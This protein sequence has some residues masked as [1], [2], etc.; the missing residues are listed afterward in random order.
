MTVNRRM[1][2]KKQTR[3]IE[4]SGADHRPRADVDRFAHEP[5]APVALAGSRSAQTRWTSRC[6]RSPA[7]PSRVSFARRRPLRC[8]ILGRRALRSQRCRAAYSTWAAVGPGDRLPAADFV[9]SSE[10]WGGQTWCTATACGGQ[11]G[12]VPARA[13]AGRRPRPRAT[14]GLPADAAVRPEGVP[15]RPRPLHRRLRCGPTDARRH[16]RAAGGIDQHPPRVHRRPSVRR[17][18]SR[19]PRTGDDSTLLNLPVDA[20]VV[21]GAGTVEW[22]KGADL[23]VQLAGEVRRRR[24]EPVHFIWVGGDLTSADWQRVRSDMDR[25]GADH[26]HFVPGSTRP[27]P[28]VFAGRRV[29]AVL[30]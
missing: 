24:A 22:R 19:P 3:G 20:A 14:G 12:A 8:S 15:Q 25:S 23:F 30:A 2:A 16:G 7:V 6:W 5:V 21:V 27:P 11:R 18:P 9:L 26:V 28:L 1:S 10:A 4:A 13:R 17:L 29:R